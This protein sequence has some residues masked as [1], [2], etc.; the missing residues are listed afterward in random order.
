MAEETHVSSGAEMRALQE[1]NYSAVD[2]PALYSS[3]DVLKEKAP[4]SD[5]MNEGSK[6]Q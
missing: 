6:F 2:L 5:G 4:M 1:G 3:S